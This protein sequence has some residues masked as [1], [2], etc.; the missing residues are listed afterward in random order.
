MAEPG[1]R[2]RWYWYACACGWRGERYR[3]ARVCQRC[4][5]PLRRVEEVVRGRGA[6]AGRVKGVRDG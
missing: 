1:A 3:N 5:G 4:R 6:A 2:G